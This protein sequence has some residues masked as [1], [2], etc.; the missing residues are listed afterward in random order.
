MSANRPPRC[1]P[2]CRA[3]RPP[4]RCWST[5]SG[6]R[7]DATLACQGSRRL[8]FCSVWAT[9]AIDSLAATARQDFELVLFSVVAG[10]I[11]AI[12]MA[13]LA[14]R[15]RWLQGPLLAITG[16]IYTVPSIAF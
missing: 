14:H 9:G 3:P 8:L 11:V 15:R 2:S 4:I 7:A 13:L 12:A 1:G 10:F 6:D 5:L 16:V